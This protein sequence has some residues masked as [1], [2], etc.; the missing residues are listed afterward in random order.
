MPSIRETVEIKASPE[1][2]FDLIVR[3]E[4]FSLYTGIISEIKATAADTYRWRVRVG[5]VSLD[6]DAVVTECVRPTHFA[7]RS[8]RGVVNSGSYHLAPSPV[9]TVMS[10]MMEYHLPNRLLEMALAPLVD[11]LIRKV[12]SDILTAVKERLEAKTADSSGVSKG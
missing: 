12:S 1:A 2:V 3:V 6:W 11:P 8:I 10:L 7:W 4:D 5:G 9:G